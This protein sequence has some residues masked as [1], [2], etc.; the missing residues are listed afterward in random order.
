[1]SRLL[2]I[3]IYI[4]LDIC[5]YVHHRVCVGV[6]ANEVLHYGVVRSKYERVTCPTQESETERPNFGMFTIC[7]NHHTIMTFHCSYLLLEICVVIC[8]DM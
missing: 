7:Q 1:M 8:M 3:I 4:N 2:Y 5:I 6:K